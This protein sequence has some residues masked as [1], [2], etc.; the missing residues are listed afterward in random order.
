M[1][2]PG[3]CTI[4]RKLP[5]NAPPKSGTPAGQTPIGQARRPRDRRSDS[6]GPCC[7]AAAARRA[8]ATASGRTCRPCR[9]ATCSCRSLWIAAARAGTLGPRRPLLRFRRQRGGIRPLG[10]STISDVRRAGA[11]QRQ[12]D[13]VVGAGD[14]ELGAAL[15]ALVAAEQRRPRSCPGRPPASSVKNSWLANLAGAAGA[16]RTRRSRC[17]AGPARPRASSSPAPGQALGRM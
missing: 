16:C 8:A 2:P 11:L 1:T 6:C 5:P 15:D 4:R 13:R 10:G 12:E 3:V 9:R 17:P 14:V 7:S